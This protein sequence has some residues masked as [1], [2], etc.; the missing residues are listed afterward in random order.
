MSSFTSRRRRRR[1][2]R[3][4]SEF[5]F[6]AALGTARGPTT[7]PHPTPPQDLRSHPRNDALV[8]AP[9]RRSAPAAPYRLARQLKPRSRAGTS[10]KER[11]RE[12]ER[13]EARRGVREKGGA[14]NC[15]TGGAG[16]GHNQRREGRS[17]D[18]YCGVGAREREREGE[19]R[20]G[21]SESWRGARRAAAQ[22]RC[23][24]VEERARRGRDSGG[25]WGGRAW[26]GLASWLHCTALHCTQ[27]SSAE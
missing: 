3:R 25:E 8:L 23:C 16:R 24:F 10:V 19:D 21:G 12:R 11:E 14:E 6:L 17:V 1:R 9:L 2:R 4:S 26:P 7:P 22:R 20:G 13:N 18:A 15:V 27:L 5:S